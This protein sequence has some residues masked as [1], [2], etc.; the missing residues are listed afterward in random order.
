MRQFKKNIL[1]K[2]EIVIYDFRIINS[3]Y[4][5]LNIDIEIYVRKD[6]STRICE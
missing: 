4:L 6:F 5:F 2:Y 1:E 3:V